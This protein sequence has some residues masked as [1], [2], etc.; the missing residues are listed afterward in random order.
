M[1]LQS[2][3]KQI[4]TQDGA[5]IQYTY[6]ENGRF[7]GRICILIKNSFIFNFE[8]APEFR[9]KGYGTQIL[10][11]LNGKELLVQKGNRAIN[12]YKRCGFQEVEEKDNFIRMRRI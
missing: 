10:N 12:L 1:I 2:K 8:V 4:E 11:S 7:V 6:F 5:A 3:S 9:N